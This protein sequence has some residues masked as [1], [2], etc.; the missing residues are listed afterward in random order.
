MQISSGR[1][2]R[3][4]EKARADPTA[5]SWVQASWDNAEPNNVPG[6]NAQRGPCAGLK[7]CFSLAAEGSTSNTRETKN[8]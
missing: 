2:D 6:S 5:F 3:E 4:E 8:G 7:S 1:E